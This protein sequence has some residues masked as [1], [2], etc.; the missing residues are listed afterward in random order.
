[1]KFP[2]FMQGWRDRIAKQREWEQERQIRNAES[3][4]WIQKNIAR[5]KAGQEVEPPWD[6]Y[7]GSMP[8]WSSWRQSDEFIL[9]DLCMPYWDN[10]DAPQRAEYLDKWNVPDDWKWWLEWIEENKLKRAE[11]DQ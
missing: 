3:Q 1:M 8:T 6:W 4:A 5:S 2:R 7:P 10:L 9:Y 11:A